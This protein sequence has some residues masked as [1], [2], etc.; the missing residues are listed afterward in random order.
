MAGLAE[1]YLD[2][3]SFCI[4]YSEHRKHSERISL[5]NFEIVRDFHTFEIL[6]LILKT[7]IVMSS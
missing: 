5:E 2:W 3:V 1:S 4:K 6:F 7:I